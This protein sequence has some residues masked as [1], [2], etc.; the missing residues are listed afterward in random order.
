MKHFGL[1]LQLKPDPDVIAQYKA[2]HRDPW[3]E[4]LQGLKQVG[5]E[6]MHIFLLGTRMFMH[7]ATTDAF[8]PARDFPRYVEQNPKA[9]EWDEL[10]RTFQQ[11]VPEA[12][13]GEWWAAMECVFD[14]DDHVA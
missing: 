8:D 12:G 1:T 10:M 3:P 14:L 4:P 6:Q 13:E 5:V 9:A 11:P 2:Y 7:M